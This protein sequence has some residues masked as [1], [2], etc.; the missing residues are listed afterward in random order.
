MEKVIAGFGYHEKSVLAFVAGIFMLSTHCHLGKI[1]SIEKAN[2]YS[3]WTT[4]LCFANLVL[5]LLP[6]NAKWQN[7]IMFD[8][9]THLFLFIYFELI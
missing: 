9:I 6:R 3:G 8:F 4:F 2:Q 5:S 1:F 7:S